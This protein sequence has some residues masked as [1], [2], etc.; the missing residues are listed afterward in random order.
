M[1]VA[2]ML[3]FSEMKNSA[4]NVNSSVSKM[5]ELCK[6][7]KQN[8]PIKT[9]TLQKFP[10]QQT[11]NQLFNIAKQIK[12]LIDVPEKIWSSLDGGEYLKV[13]TTTVK[14]IPSFFY[15]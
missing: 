13:F 10:K 5:Q 15:Q 2:S 4:A 6:S 8:Y 12:L 14:H 3:A 1:N 11:Q 7:L 9:T